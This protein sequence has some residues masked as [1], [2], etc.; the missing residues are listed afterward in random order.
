MDCRQTRDELIGGHDLS[1]AAER[2]ITDCNECRRFA[3]DLRLI[4]TLRGSSFATPALLRERTLDECHKRLAQRTAPQS[5][6]LW[7]RCR[8]ICGSPQ[9]IAGAAALCVIVVGW[10]L[11]QEM[12]AAQSGDSVVSIKLAFVQLGIQNFA[13]ALLFPILWLITPKRHQ[14]RI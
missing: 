10:W 13:A 7:Q 3:S 6:S 8:R 5:K 2:H 4:A 9:L 1:A 12:N 14:R 11:A